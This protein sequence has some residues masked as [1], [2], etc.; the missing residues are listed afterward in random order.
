MADHFIPQSYLKNFATSQKKS[1]YVSAIKTSEKKEV[2]KVNIKNICAEDNLYTFTA[3]K[4]PDQRMFERFYDKNIE[5]YYPEAYSILID[6]TRLTI[7]L[8]EKERILV[9]LLSMYFRSPR[10]FKPLKEYFENFFNRDHLYGKTDKNGNL[11]V[12]FDGK[13][14]NFNISDIDEVR[15]KEIANL[16]GTWLNQQLKLQI[17]FVKKIFMRN[18]SVSRIRG[19][20]KLITSDNP[21]IMKSTSDQPRHHFFPFSLYDPS[22]IIYIPID[23][24][25]FVTIFPDSETTQNSF[26]IYRWP[27]SDFFAKY[28]NALQNENCQEW[29][30]GSPG[31][32]KRE[33]YVF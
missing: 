27:Q 14:L 26:D 5:Q 20:I 25:H 24:F 4:V 31:T 12:T 32:L 30:I 3:V 2:H 33:F 21:V 8:L 9:G 29:L 18:I 11:K 23:P 1:F 13:E 7:S 17:E 10:F 19:D 6:P 22:N 15:S 16:K 28:L